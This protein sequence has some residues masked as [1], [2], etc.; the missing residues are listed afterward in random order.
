MRR[1]WEPAGAAYLFLLPALAVYALW[2]LLPMGQSL[3]YSLF[4]WSGVGE[5]K[6]YVG[7]ANFRALVQDAVFWQAL[8]HNAILLIMSLL[9]QLPLAFLLAVVFTRGLRGEG[10]FR[11]VSFAPMVMPT[12][13][14]AVL[15]TFI[16]APLEAHGLLNS[17]L[18]A[19]GG[20]GW[21][22]GWLGESDPDL[23]LWAVIVTVCWRYVGFHLVLFTAGIQTI[24]E[25]LHEAARLDGAT[26]GQVLRY[27]T[28]PLLARVATISA[29]L[30][31]VGSLKYFDIIYVMTR[32]DGPYPHAT[33][34]VATYM[35]KLAF[36]QQRMGYGSAVAVALFG[37]SLAVAI[38]FS[39]GMARR[40]EASVGG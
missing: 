19:W 12:V 37:I 27:V 18:A 39:A 14:I 2:V 21:T 36:D 13:A 40:A 22:H 10:L 7:L 9:L 3:Y 20:E 25:E 6:T 28:I 11:T 30:S 26:E 17:A 34:L 24:P 31:L 32:G 5:H 1:K 33:E 29:T 35:Y 16:Y 15:W 4:A 8:G 38:A 23:S